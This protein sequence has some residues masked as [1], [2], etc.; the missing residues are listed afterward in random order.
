VTT[1]PAGV[2]QTAVT[3]YQV[4]LEAED[5]PGLADYDVVTLVH[6]CTGQ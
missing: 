4:L 1:A 3:T 5:C 2:G 6:E